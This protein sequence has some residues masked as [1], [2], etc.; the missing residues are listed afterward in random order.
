MGNAPAVSIV[1]TLATP[2]TGLPYLHH[3]MATFV[4]EDTTF[5]TNFAAATGSHTYQDP[6]SLETVALR[7]TG[8]NW[9]STIQALGATSEEPIWTWLAAYWNPL[10]AADPTTGLR[11]PTTVQKSDFVIIGRR[12]N[13]VQSINTFEFTNNTAGRVRIRVNRAQYLY[14]SNTPAGALADVTIVADGALTVAQLAT[15]AA[16]ALNAVTDF[17]D[18]FLASAALGVVTVTADVAGYPLILEVTASTPGPTMA[19]AIT[20]ANTPGDYE[21]D[22]DTLQNA[23]ELNPG[24]DT[25][26][27]RVF[28]FVTDLQGDD[29]VNAEGMEWVEDQEDDN[30][31]PRDYQ[32]LSWSTSGA[33]LITIGGNQVGNFNPASTDSAAQ[34]AAAANGGSG[35]TRAGVWDHP[36]YEFLVGAMLGRCIGYMPGEVSFTSKVLQGSV[37][38]AQM[39]PI[40]AG[41]NETL[42]LGDSRRFNYYSSEGPGLL[43]QDKWGYNADGFFV[44]QKWTTDYVAYQVRVDLLTWMQLNNITPYT[45]NSIEAGA[46]IVAA[47]IAKI[48]AVNPASIIVAFVGRDAV[49]PANIVARVYY[50][51]NGTGQA[52]GV[53]NRFGTPSNPIPI[54]ILNS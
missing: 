33:R 27:H 35:W 3:A 10:G 36:R 39:S 25:V 21:T 38:A 47:A 42:T 52:N 17:S 26:P 15:A 24:G 48:P 49:N 54:T 41:A 6:D 43:G 5:A 1:A 16:A 19:Q 50:D 45:N 12:L 9:Q 31:P 32:F 37:P 2:S 23:I 44:D 7:L 40:D 30:T 28:Y 22:L 8:D 34:T 18:H 51:Y 13:A 29:V 14:S 53:I 11:S 46:G 20:T 4:P